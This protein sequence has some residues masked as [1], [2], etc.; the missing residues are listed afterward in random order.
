M[1]KKKIKEVPS[2]LRTWF[3]I[4]FIVD[5]LFGIPLLF[6]PEAFLRFCG[7]PVNDLLPLRLV[8]AALLAI[9]GVS[10][11]NN[12]SGFE[13]YN[14]LLNLKIIWSVLAVLGILVT[15]SQG[16][17]SKGWLFFFI[18][19]VFSLIWTYYKLKI[20]NIFKLK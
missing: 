6:F 13:T 3:L 19:L 18:F 11:L 2:S 15:M 9:G 5:Y 1:V 7:L 4:H 10:Y 14:S 12:K 17:P 8:G 16:Y 20:N